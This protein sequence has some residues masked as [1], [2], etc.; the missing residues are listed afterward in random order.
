M[1]ATALSI[2]VSAYANKKAG[3]KVPTKA[4]KDI[5]LHF[6]I[7]IVLILL[8]AIKNIIM[9]ENT[10]LNEP[11]CKADKPSKLFLISINELPQIKDKAIK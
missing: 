2:W 10:I 7:G 1:E 9:E 8:N 6:L 4:D 11:S 5:H 3:K